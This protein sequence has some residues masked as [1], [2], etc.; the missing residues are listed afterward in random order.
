MA[1]RQTVS[2]YIYWIRYNLSAQKQREFSF[3]RIHTSAD[4][5][6]SHIVGVPN[7]T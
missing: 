2:V 1:H 6:V 7:K 3:L 4:K 5:K